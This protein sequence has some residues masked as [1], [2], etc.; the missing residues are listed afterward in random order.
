ME[1]NVVNVYHEY[2]DYAQFVEKEYAVVVSILDKK[3]MRVIVIV[4]KSDGL[5]SD[6]FVI[7]AVRNIKTFLNINNTFIQNISLAEFPKLELW[8]S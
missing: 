2:W 8:I 5:K 4:V 6:V 7:T 1:S 3:N